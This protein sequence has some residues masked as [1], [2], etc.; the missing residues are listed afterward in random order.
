MKKAIELYNCQ[1][2]EYVL[3]LNK[4][5]I[6]CFTRLKKSIFRYFIFL[7][8]SFALIKILKQYKKL[9]K[10]RNKNTFLFFCTKHFKN[11]INLFCAHVVKKRIINK[12]YKK[13][14]LIID[15]YAH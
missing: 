11:I 8:T 14:L 3:I 1:R 10:A 9:Q 7:I 12:S 2:F 13:I 6:R 4:I 15:I 5:K